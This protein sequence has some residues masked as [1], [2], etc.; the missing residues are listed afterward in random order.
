MSNN[1]DS[2]SESNITNNENEINRS[3]ENNNRK[4]SSHWEY[5][6]VFAIAS[7]I[8][9]AI[10][11]TS[12]FN[13]NTEV[14]DPY[15]EDGNICGHGGLSDYN[16]IYFYRLDTDLFK[17]RVCVSDCPEV[18]N[19]LLKCFPTKNNPQ[20]KIEK[21]SFYASKQCNFNT[22]I[23]IYIIII[24]VIHFCVAID[25]RI[26]TY[27][28]KAD[29]FDTLFDTIKKSNIMIYISFGL[30]LCKKS[31]NYLPLI[32]FIVAIAFLLITLFFPMIAY[33]GA[34]V[35]VFCSICFI[36][37]LLLFFLQSIFTSTLTI[38]IILGAISSIPSFLFMWMIF[39][40]SSIYRDSILDIYTNSLWKNHIHLP[41]IVPL[42]I[43]ALYSLILSNSYKVF[44]NLIG[45]SNHF[46]LNSSILPITELYQSMDLSVM[47]II[48]IAYIILF[49]LYM[50]VFLSQIV[51]YIY[52]QY[53]YI[54]ISSPNQTTLTLLMN[55]F[56]SFWL[57]LRYHFGSVIW[58]SYRSIY[59]QFTISNCINPNRKED[60]G[61]L[62][63]N[64][65]CL[66]SNNDYNRQYIRLGLMLI[67][68]ISVLA[69]SIMLFKA[70]SSIYIA[71]GLWI[72][73]SF[74]IAN[75]VI[76][77]PS[78]FNDILSLEKECS[79]SIPHFELSS[80]TN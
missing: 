27:L 22:F 79:T 7:I 60:F 36:D 71:F 45:K 70:I 47:R 64:G 9:I 1:I 42:I 57:L 30:K 40:Y 12:S 34:V 73:V 31:L 20:C 17:K 2:E 66:I 51:K 54:A 24:I 26:N 16:K 72:I 46:D 68:S 55:I 49:T 75:W 50:I 44:I 5:Y 14:F 52:A 59:L 19:G 33:I 35:V 37:S 69:Y 74:P 43:F 38:E 4:C 25:Y 80:I 28:K 67:A 62:V 61:Y 65:K 29:L 21:E 76:C 48:Q 41:I 39:N 11:I 13:I 58:I 3:D 8:Y 23:L 15:D 77:F 78:S 10:S 63:K 32:D 6:I 56:Y 18:Y 53:S